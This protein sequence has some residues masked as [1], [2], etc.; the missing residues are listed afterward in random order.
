L[1]KGTGAARCSVVVPGSPTNFGPNAGATGRWRWARLPR[2]RTVRA[3]SA[4][5]TTSPLLRRRHAATQALGHGS[6]FVCRPRRRRCRCAQPCARATANQP[7]VVRSTDLSLLGRCDGL[8]SD[9]DWEAATRRS[10]WCSHKSSWGRRATWSSHTDHPV[11]LGETGTDRADEVVDG[12]VLDALCIVMDS[13]VGGR[14]D[15]CDLV[16]ELVLA[17]CGPVL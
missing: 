2:A 13:Q 12:G 9:A 11:N 16:S 10:L 5:V 4:G 6:G 7:T 14:T 15:R 1:N 3:R 17:H 8:C